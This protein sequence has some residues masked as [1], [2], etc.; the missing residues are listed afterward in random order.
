MAISTYSDLIAQIETYTKHA[1]VGV[2]AAD[3]V[4][5]AEARLNRLFRTLDM[6]DRIHPSVITEGQDRLGLPDNWRGMRTARVGGHTCELVT[7]QQLENMAAHALDVVTGG[8][9]AIADQ[10]LRFYP[11]LS[12]DSDVEVL[13]WKAIPPLS[14][15]NASNW[16][17][18][19]HPDAYLAACLAET[20]PFLKDDSLTALWEQKLK[21]ITDGINRDDH[22]AKYGSSP[23][24]M[25][26]G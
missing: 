1:D 16:L 2:Q 23:L 6:E 9:C 7:P 13:Y 14:A 25:R 24:R 5:I 15:S 12:A 22:N 20:G 3:I 18:E 26:N 10:Q 8:Y 21:V 11:P 17:L 4:R 19:K